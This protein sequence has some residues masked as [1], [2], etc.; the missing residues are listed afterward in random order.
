MVDVMSVLQMIPHLTALELALR[1][2]FIPALG[3]CSGLCATCACATGNCL[4]A[5]GA[6]AGTAPA[7]AAGAGGAAGDDGKSDPRKVFPLPGGGWFGTDGRVHYGGEAS[8]SVSLN[9]PI[10]ST[11]IASGKVSA[12][13]DAGAAPG[14]DPHGNIVDLNWNASASGNVGPLH[15]SVSSSGNVGV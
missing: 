11:P 9:T 13:F 6:A 7:A 12:G 5:G 2:W 14:S 1:G 8:A 3:A 15:G 10:G 4:S